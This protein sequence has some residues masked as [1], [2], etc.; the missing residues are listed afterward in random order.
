M[1]PGGGG[2]QSRVV[3]KKYPTLLGANKALH[4]EEILG[5]KDHRQRNV[6]LVC[7]LED[8]SLSL[9]MLILLA[10]QYTIEDYHLARHP[11]GRAK[12]MGLC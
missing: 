5:S 3:S 11:Q 10:Y 6:G 2:I 7:H 8:V 1:H 9:N 4:L 12:Q